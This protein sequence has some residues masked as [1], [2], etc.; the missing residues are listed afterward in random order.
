MLTKVKEHRGIL[1]AL[2]TASLLL[3]AKKMERYRRQVQGKTSRGLGPVILVVGIHSQA[4]SDIWN[5][6]QYRTV[7]DG[8]LKR[9]KGQLMYYEV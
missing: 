7:Y 2:G 4:L 5:T 9:K 3:P 1:R 6:V 8:I